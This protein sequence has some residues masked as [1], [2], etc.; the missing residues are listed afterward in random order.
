MDNADLREFV[1]HGLHLRSIL[2]GGLLVC[3]VPN[4]ADSVPRRLRIIPI[5]HS[6]PFAL[7]IGFFC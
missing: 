5:M 7:A 6:A 3:S 4:V 1:D 2:L